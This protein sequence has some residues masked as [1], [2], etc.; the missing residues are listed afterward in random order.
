VKRSA[1]L[2]AGIFSPL[3]YQLSYPANPL[4]TRNWIVFPNSTLF[5]LFYFCPMKRNET[6]RVTDVSKPL[7]IPGAVGH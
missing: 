1:T 3:L 4:K 2:V 6:Y 7:R 5:C